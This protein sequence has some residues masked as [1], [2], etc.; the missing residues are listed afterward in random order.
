MLKEKITIICEGG[1]KYTGI[2]INEK[3]SPFG[4]LQWLE[5]KTKNGTVKINSKYIVSILKNANTN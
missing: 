3:L 5:L 2:Q 1:W 4:T